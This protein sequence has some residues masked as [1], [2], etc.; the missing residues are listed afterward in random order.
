MMP[1]ERDPRP[2]GH[3]P[4]ATSAEA[5]GA[6]P[7]ERPVYRWYHK[8][9]AAVLIALCVEIGLFLVVFPWTGYWENNYFSSVSPQWRRYWMNPYWRGAVSGLGV[10]NLFLALAE[11]FRLRRFAGK[12]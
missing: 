1:T 6:I 7:I 12:S 5:A 2:V 4:A 8:L 3:P 9:S 11:I 10:A